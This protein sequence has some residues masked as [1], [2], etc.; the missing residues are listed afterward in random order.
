MPTQGAYSGGEPTGMPA[1]EEKNYPNP[2]KNTRN[3]QKIPG[4][5]QA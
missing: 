2:K 4:V 3:R 5:L 1:L